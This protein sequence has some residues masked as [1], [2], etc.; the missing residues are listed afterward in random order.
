LDEEE[1]LSTIAQEGIADIEAG[2]FVLIET[3]AD[4]EALY[5]STMARV[6]AKSEADKT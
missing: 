6:R 1:D 3:K 4:A 2:R 5:E